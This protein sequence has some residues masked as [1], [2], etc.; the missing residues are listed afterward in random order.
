MEEL[1]IQPEAIVTTR[2]SLTV[3]E[4][5][6]ERARGWGLIRGAR[7]NLS[8]TLRR[9]IEAGLQVTEEKPGDGRGR[10]VGGGGDGGNV[11]AGDRREG[12]E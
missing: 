10:P 7:P 6:V 4:D 2:V 12:G 5:V 11:G 8:A 1:R 3:Y 9:L